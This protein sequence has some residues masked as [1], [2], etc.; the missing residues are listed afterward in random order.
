MKKILSIISSPRGSAS[1]S[2]QLAQAL[3]DQLVAAYPGSMVKTTDLTKKNFPHLE[4]SHITSFFTPPDQH[5]AKDKEAIRHSDEAIKEIVEADTIIIGA[6]MYNFS[7]HSTLKAWLDHIV[8]KGLTFSYS[9]KG[10]EGLIKGKKVYLILSTG[11]IFSEGAWKAHDF[12]EPYLRF[13]LGFIGLTDITVFRVEG[14]AIP[15]IKD[16]A[17]EK[18]IAGISLPVAS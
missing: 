7:I 9:E 8:R 16:T 6:P 14:L 13:I 10:P 5:T 1:A 11:G 3:T 12:V 2:I 4:E 18:A 15:A 17:M